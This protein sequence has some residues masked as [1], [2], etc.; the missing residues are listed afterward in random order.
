[1]VDAVVC[2][3]RGGGEYRAEHVFALHE[4]VAHWWPKDRALRFVALTDTPIRMRGIE[5]RPLR[6]EWQ[7]W[8]A[9]MEMFLGAHDDLGTILYL[10]LDTMVV[11]GLGDIARTEHLTLLQD[12]YYPAKVQSG[13]MVL[14]R[15]DRAEACGAFFER[16][17]AT[18]RN[19]RG[20]GEFLDSMWRTTA[21]RWQTALP[22]QVV[23]YKVHV[24]QRPKQT[25]PPRARVVC[26]HGNPRPWATALWEHR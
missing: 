25:I 18:M 14:P 19:A 6:Q 20:D 21:Q 12:F 7:G 24:R 1:M 5:E 17:Q 16:P 8:W 23:S 26:F 4:G 3:L 15:A 9:K 2:V 10:D 11:G 13:M 22:D